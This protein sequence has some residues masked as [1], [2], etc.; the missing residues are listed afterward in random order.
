[1]A[2][3]AKKSFNASIYAASRPT[4]PKALFDYIFAYHESGILPHQ[5][6]ASSPRYRPRWDL[7]VDLGCG[8]GQATIELT[9]FK[10]VV[11]VEPGEKMLEAARK[12]LKEKIGDS[13]ESRFEFV[14]SSAEDLSFLG[15]ST[16]DLVIAAQAAHW[17][18]YSKLWPE[19][20]RVLRP[21]GTVAFW[22][23]SEFRLSAYPSLTPL[24]TNYAQ[25]TDPAT[26]IGPHW[27]RPGRTIL[28]NHLLDVPEPSWGKMDRVF[29][30]GSHYP[31]LP[32]PL[33][34]ILRT[35][36]T[37]GGLLTYFRSWSSLHTYLERGGEQGIEDRFWNAL[38][39]G[40]VKEGS[41]AVEESDELM[42]E[43]PIGMI[44][45]KKGEK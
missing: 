33:P 15:S 13:A 18:D 11:G 45:V 10:K 29:F 44:L 7:A 30:T 34:V 23:Y 3:F 26:S 22:V 28:E 2:T 14:N 39:E 31:D 36:T 8:T 4:Y 20:D 41:T 38:R 6:S 12:Y 5:Q 37:W 24:I 21:S 42:V 32:S 1:M 19:L 27:Q 43:W 35:K 40:A 17:F 25:G 9:P 16:V